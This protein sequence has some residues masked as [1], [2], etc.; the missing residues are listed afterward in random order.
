LHAAGQRRLLLRG[1]ERFASYFI[2]I[3]LEHV[4][5]KMSGKDGAS[6]AS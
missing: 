6:P 5:G 2:E 1:E 3:V 4:R